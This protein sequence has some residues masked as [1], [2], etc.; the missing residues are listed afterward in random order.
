MAH[1]SLITVNRMLTASL[2]VTAL[3]W[4]DAALAQSERKLDLSTPKQRTDA[5]KPKQNARPRSTSCAEFGPGFVRLPG[6]D[7]CTRMG[8]GVEM[9]VGAVP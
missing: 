7:S 5:P 8:G 6:S 1:I 3:A 2:L 4:P 9:G